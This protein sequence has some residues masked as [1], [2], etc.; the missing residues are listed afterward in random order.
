MKKCKVVAICL[1]V[2]L[3]GFLVACNQADNSLKI[4]TK[5]KPFDGSSY[6]RVV[7]DIKKTDLHS[8]SSTRDE[9]VVA[10][11]KLVF[12]LDTSGEYN[13]LK[14]SFEMTYNQ[15]ADTIDI[16]KTDKIETFALFTKL[17]MLPIE[18][19]RKVAIMERE[20]KSNQSYEIFADYQ[21]KSA[22]IGKPILFAEDG[23]II[24]NDSVS[25]MGMN[26][27]NVPF[28][29]EYL[30]YCLRAAT[31]LE[32]G[33]QLL[34][35]SSVL[36]DSFSIGKYTT[37]SMIASVGEE[38]TQLEV[39]N[40]R[41]IAG[42]SQNDLGNPYLNTLNVSLKLNTTN[43]GPGTVLQYVADEFHIDEQGEVYCGQ[44]KESTHKDMSKVLA[45]ISTTEFENNVQ[46]YI[47]TY[48]IADYSVKQ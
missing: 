16:G 41:G 22:K 21:T 30:Y 11:G 42:L 33:Q 43:S 35:N 13:Q 1:A 24:E 10:T 44:K 12:E 46:K 19:R 39:P 23:T 6:E 31:Q 7:Y 38:T 18:S 47:T 36:F 34:F 17:S 28:D 20:G 32:L 9:A 3:M 40:L 8:G 26:Y 2:F 25:T 37:Y 27:S 14:M 15:L 5:E 45:Q 29:N 48:T 4:D